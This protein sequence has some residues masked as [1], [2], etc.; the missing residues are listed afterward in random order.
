MINY[1]ERRKKLAAKL[2][3]NSILYLFSG[4]ELMRSY[5]EAYPF[6]ADRS[7]LYFTGLER[8]DMVLVISKL[9]NVVEESLYIPHFDETLAKW[10]GGRMLKEDAS[11]I[12]GILKVNE[13]SELEDSF[14][15]YFHI[16]RAYGDPTVYVD[17]Y[18]FNTNQDKTEGLKF[19]HNLQKEYPNIIIKDTY[20]LI[21]P[22]RQIKDK[23]EIA[24]IK[25]AEE[26]TN[27]GI[28]AMMRNVKPG[29]N[30]KYLEA[31]FDFTLAEDLATNMFGTICA[32][33]K[34]ATI[35]HYHDNNQVIND[36]ELVLI[37]L[38]AK[39]NNYGAD[40]SR[41]FPANGKFT[42]RQAEI[43]QIVLNAQILVERLAKPG[44]TLKQLNT[45]VVEF[46]KRELP[47]H[48]L[49]KDVSEYYYHSV[50]HEIGLDTHD[51]FDRAETILQPGMVISNEP[52]LYIDDEAI[53][54][55][56]EDDLLIT[57]TGCE[58][59]SKDI[60]KRIDD[61]EA[62]QKK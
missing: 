35:L 3:N 39:R 19:A 48:G 45:A 26:I 33:G 4:K 11:K 62:L 49:T 9:N 59:L 21:K 30:E 6:Y 57:E 34:R 15:K 8:E 60:I 10:V 23:D 47:K 20:P 46:Y 29:M 50:S 13:L 17:V 42:P 24:L 55:R 14:K 25:E 7:F 43:Y 18:K 54:I 1:I 12:S 31:I 61:I 51:A 58:N 27:K 36:G 22:I 52:G 28:R 44:I 38:G 40:V 5:D 53:G 56:I 2:D 41:T 32:A 16:A 37:D